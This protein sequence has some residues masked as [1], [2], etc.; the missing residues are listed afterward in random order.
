[1]RYLFGLLVASSLWQT[2]ALAE[3]GEL[4]ALSRQLSIEA[5]ALL[6]GARAVVGSFPSY[7]QRYAFEHVSFF[8]ASAHRFEYT[9]WNEGPG[10]SHPRDPIIVG[11]F[12]RLERDLFNARQT[13]ADLFGPF[14]DSTDNHP[15][16]AGLFQRL[17]SCERLVQEIFRNL[18]PI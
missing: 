2:P 12:R 11:A 13:F 16:E 1:M 9:V 7:R 17:A 4:R 5:S 6:E 8:H 18:P 3:H 14:S 15:M 10:D